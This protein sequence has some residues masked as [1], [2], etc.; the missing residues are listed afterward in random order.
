MAVGGFL[1]RCDVF[2]DFGFWFLWSAECFR[3]SARRNFSVE[4]R[5]VFYSRIP[6][7]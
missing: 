5:A 1:E 3:F 4:N 7:V 2:L 6:L